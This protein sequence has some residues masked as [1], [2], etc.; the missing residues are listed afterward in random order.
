MDEKRSDE[1]MEAL[2]VTDLQYIETLAPDTEE[3]T[4]ATK[5]LETLYKTKLESEKMAIDNK[6]A[7]YD[8]VV[9]IGMT[10]LEVILPILA[11]GVWVRD[12]YK[13]E[14]LDEMLTSK[15]LRDLSKHFRP[16]KR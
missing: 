4:V 2:I 7:M 6:N 13:L 11:Y 16:T 3:R 15:T 8:R 14:G 12:G 10:S 9:K 1:L 5:N